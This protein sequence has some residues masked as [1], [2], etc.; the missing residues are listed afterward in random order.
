MS[1]D[2]QELLADLLTPVEAANYIG[3]T[4]NTLAKWRCDGTHAIPY[5]KMGT[6]KRSAIRYERSGLDAV[7]DRWRENGSGKVSSEDE[8]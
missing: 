7:L 8:L 5:L 2:L 3:S 1:Q 6:G 4:T